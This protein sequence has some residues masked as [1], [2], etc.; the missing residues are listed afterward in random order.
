MTCFY[1]DLFCLQVLLNI[2]MY[3]YMLLK[4]EHQ[5]NS[6]PPTKKIDNYLYI[7]KNCGR[8]L[9]QLNS[10]YI[11]IAS[12]ELRIGLHHFEPP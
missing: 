4:T 3:I 1:V 6:P 11:T 12:H 8:R 5:C 9:Q 10:L 2:S 7:F